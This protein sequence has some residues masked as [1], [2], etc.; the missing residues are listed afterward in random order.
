[1]RNRDPKTTSGWLAVQAPTWLV[2]V[3]A[4][5]AVFQ[6]GTIIVQAWLI[7][8]IIARAIVH[9]AGLG[10]LSGFLIALLVTLTVRTALDTVRGVTAAGASARVRK[11]L[12]P[13]L[14]RHLTEAGPALRGKHGS[15]ALATSVIEQIDLLDPWY[16]RYLPQSVLTVVMI[17][18]LLIAVFLHDWLAGILLLVSLPLIPLFMVLIGMGAQSLAEQQQQA[19]ARLGGVFYDRLR[20][21]D[22]IRRLGAGSREAERVGMMIEAFRQ[23][24]MAVLR[25]AFVSSAVL[26][27]FTAVAIA[28][29][30]IYIGLG[31]IGHIGFGPAPE[32]T[33][34]SGLFMLLIA[35]ELFMPLRQLSQFWHDRAAATAAAGNIR[36]LLATDPA[37]PEPISPVRVN[38]DSPC[39]L[40]LRKLAVDRPGRGTILDQV[41]LDV[42]PGERLLIA[43]PSGSGKSTLLFVL[44]GL[45]APTAGVVRIDGNDLAGISRSELARIRGWM[46]QQPG[47]LTDSLAANIAAGLPGADS[48]AIRD[49]ARLAGLDPLLR[50]L[51]AGMDTAI[52]QDGE[53]L[54]GGQLRRIALARALVASRPLLLLDEPTASLDAE[55]ADAIWKTLDRVGTERAVTI[56]IASHDPAAPDWSHRTVG[57]RNGRLLETPS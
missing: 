50:Q 39:A 37:Q 51:P 24:T 25:V 7:A 34:Y 11:G 22:T 14:F 21:L 8:H 40:S 10:E 46:G 56:V 4:T 3:M 17:P 6:A 27:F 44:A 33:L 47:L 36:N 49:A 30:A 42:E 1:M 52:R 12:R 41:D 48:A 5:L 13:R 31:L 43:G 53:G 35:P 45:L 9:D 2:P 18:I 29:L 20:G 26:E 23:R 28:A 16:A 19:L 32:L 38:V 54:S 57:L 55:S 15:G